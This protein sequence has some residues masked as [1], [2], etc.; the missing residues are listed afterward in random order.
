[1]F[2]RAA[3]RLKKY[4]WTQGTYGGVAG[5]NCLLGALS[6]LQ[7]D[8]LIVSGL[9]E[10]IQEQYPDRALINVPAGFGVVVDFN[11]HPD[12]TLDDILLVLDKAAR[13]AEEKV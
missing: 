11:D 13:K 2:D 6:Q 4:G 7:A 9:A 3:Q 12:T 10:V 1:M 8:A 5:P